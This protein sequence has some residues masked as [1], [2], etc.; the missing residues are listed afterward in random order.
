[1]R[2]VIRQC[3]MLESGWVVA[4]TGAA[5]AGGLF[6]FWLLG[7]VIVGQ[8]GWLESSFWDTWMGRSIGRLAVYSITCGFLVGIFMA[9]YWTDC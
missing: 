4:G 2:I 8:M 7:F 6:L 1:M 9:P 5:V 3:Q